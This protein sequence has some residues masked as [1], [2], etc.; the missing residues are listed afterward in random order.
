MK[1]VQPLRFGIMCDGRTL[2]R[3]QW[4][5]IR[6]LCESGCA[7][8]VLLI[9]DAGEEKTPASGWRKWRNY[10]Y[11]QMLYRMAKRF[12]FRIPAMERVP[13][14]EVLD[15]LPVLRCTTIRKGKY[16]EYFSDS[17]LEKITGYRLD[18]VLRYGFNIIRGKV[19]DVPRYGVWSYHHGDEMLFRG[20]PVGLWEIY[21]RS[22]VNGVVLQRLNNLI[23]AGVI[24]SRRTY[25]T[26]NH[27]YSEHVE[28]MLWHNADMPSEVC[29]KIVL[30]RHE[31]STAPHSSTNA[32]VNKVP[33]NRA[34]SVFLGRLSV[35]RIRFHYRRLFRQEQW[36]IGTGL[37]TDYR[38]IRPQ[39]L[40]IFPAHGYAADPFCFTQNGKKYVVYEEY[41]YRIR[42]GKISLAWL[43][44]DLRVEYTKCV[45][46]KQYH[47]AYPYVFRWEEN[48]YMIPETA[49]EGNVQLYRWNAAEETFE[50]EN[51]LAD[52]PAVDASLL[53]YENRWWLFCG[54]R[55]GL[56]NEK[57]YIYHADS[58][59]GEYRPHALNPVKTTPAGAR[60]GGTFFREADHWIRPAQ[61]SVRWYG[62]KT[63][64]WKISRLTDSE[65]TEEPAGE[66]VPQ[67]GWPYREG[68]HTFSADG[69]FYVFDAKRRRSGRAA[70]WAQLKK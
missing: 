53:F 41:D 5:S 62:E 30:G 66:L 6:L 17:D 3:W 49:E 9:T 21:R 15:G 58:L 25:R 24:L 12:L 67:A 56:P 27:S 29:K 19:L 60:M 39:W 69:P 57:L 68:V 35:N 10:P 28:K 59:S 33:G 18:F 22:P 34:M 45:L 13:M 38:N 1:P 2:A 32:S 48:V 7:E 20:G 50:F 44:D 11:K 37:G 16:S 65:Y 54:L 63:V 61:Y 47:L 26:V 46:E 43:D 36:M 70:F 4:E 14:P 8:P 55:N 23:D 64:F 42:R 40:P 51:V 31:L 52:I